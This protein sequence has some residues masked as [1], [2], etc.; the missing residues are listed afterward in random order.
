MRPRP[1]LALIVLFAAAAAIACGARE[2]PAEKP[3][4][5]IE[6]PSLGI[7]LV[8]PPSDLK[9]VRNDGGVVVLE[10]TDKEGTIT[11]A[12]GTAEEDSNLVQAVKDHQ[13]AI[14]AREGS[15]YL[16][17]RELVTPLG[18]AY[19]SR[20]RYPEGGKTVEET[21][22]VTLHP[23]G[24]GVLTL[25]SVYPAADDSSARIQTLLGIVVGIEALQPAGAGA[26]S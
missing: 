20:G 22:I 2:A 13:A 12:R 8:D 5:R 25:T 16:G 6:C 21:R 11:I 4:A 23:S 19:W 15:E 9:L 7:V 10:P 3:P 1:T 14:E 26:P 18:S 17:V 24:N